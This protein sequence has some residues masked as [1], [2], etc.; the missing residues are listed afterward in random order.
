MKH[1]DEK[2][3]GTTPLEIILKFKKSSNQNDESFLGEN[4][5]GDNFLG[6]NKE[7]SF[8]GTADQNEDTSKYWF[9]TNKVNTIIDIHK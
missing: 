2:L 4:N 9:S 7:N 6:E 8:L 1:I 5:E 3:G